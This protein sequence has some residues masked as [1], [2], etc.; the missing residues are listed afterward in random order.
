MASTPDQQYFTD[1]KTIGDPEQCCIT[2]GGDIIDIGDGTMLCSWAEVDSPLGEDIS[3][4]PLSS[5]CSLVGSIAPDLPSDGS[6]WDLPEW[7]Q[8]GFDALINSFSSIWDIFKPTPD[9]PPT[10]GGGI[11][12]DG[13]P[14]PPPANDTAKYVMIGGGVLLLVVAVV[15]LTRKK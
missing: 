6:G 7:N 4:I 2:L 14:P 1:T 13:S 11:P 5:A 9:A 10:G 15:L 12:P 8:S 3:E